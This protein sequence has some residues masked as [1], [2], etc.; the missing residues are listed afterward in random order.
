ML[1]ECRKGG[2]GTRRCPQNIG[3]RAFLYSTMRG[4]FHDLDDQFTEAYG[5]VIG[6]GQRVYRAEAGAH[7]YRR[8]LVLSAA[9]TTVYLSV[10]ARCLRE[11]AGKG[12]R[13]CRGLF[14]SRGFV[15]FTTSPERV[16]S[17]QY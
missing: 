6:R 3:R 1:A 5:P 2:G 13:L 4:P 10:G 16:A 17:A 14:P 12:C 9:G 8:R 7:P 15:K 11:K